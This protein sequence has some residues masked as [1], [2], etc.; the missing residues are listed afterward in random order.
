MS[1]IVQPTT[2]QNLYKIDI[3]ALTCHFNNL[4][5]VIIS[6]VLLAPVICNANEGEAPSIPKLEA[7]QYMV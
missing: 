3:K 1:I 5:T 6:K 7:S 4:A 2:L